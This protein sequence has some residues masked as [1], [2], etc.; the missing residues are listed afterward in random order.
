MTKMAPFLVAATLAV[1]F[2]PTGPAGAQTPYTAK[3]KLPHEVHWG[4]AVLPAG[5]Y[6]LAMSSINRPLSIVDEAGR[7]R[8]FVYGAQER[9]RAAQPAAL[10]VTNDGRARTVRSLNCPEWGVNIVYRPFTRAERQLLA[11]GDA[12][13]RVG[14]RLASR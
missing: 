2:G 6:T 12:V 3:V 9:S 7:T 1:A 10:L 4:K 11:S 8:A 5:E 13:E 14:V